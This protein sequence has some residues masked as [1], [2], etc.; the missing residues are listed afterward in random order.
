MECGRR[1]ERRAVRMKQNL[2]VRDSLPLVSK[3]S[4][5]GDLKKVIQRAVSMIGGMEKLVEKGDTILVKPNYNTAH[6]YPGSSDPKFVKA[7]TEL[8]YEAGAERVVLGERS[9]LL[10]TRKVLETTGILKVAEEAGAQVM[11]FGRKSWRR[12]RVPGGQYLKT[13]S[14]AREALEIEKIV[15]VPLMKTHHAADFTGSIKLAM[16]FV[17]PFFDQI[18]FHM[19]RL[20]EKLAELSLIVQPDLIIMDARKVFITRGPATG[21]LRS[22]NMILASGSQ[23]A[24]DIEGLKILRS[25]PGNSL[26]ENIWG[27]TQI[28]HAI[29][30]GL[31]PHNENE[32]TVLEA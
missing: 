11:I 9:S 10:N 2:F 32:Y 5:E 21:E 3:V 7:V 30:L 13:V 28:Q 14:I 26:P 8:I 18:R 29:K 27:L 6:P 25:Y 4:G 20:K 23:I 31:G 24:I 15:Y 22:P 1:A 17:N 19:R 12:V 16:G